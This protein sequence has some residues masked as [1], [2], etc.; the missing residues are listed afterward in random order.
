MRISN[1]GKN[2]IKYFEGLY[3]HAYRCPAGVLTI[4]W[5]CTEGVTEGM[6]ITT[7]RA[8][9]LLTAELAK[10]EAAVARLVRVPLTQH[11]FDALVS[12]AFNVGSGAL[13]RSTLLRKLNA[14]DYAAVPGELARWTRGGGRVLPGLVKRRRAEA[15]LWSSPDAEIHPIT[16]PMAQ[17]V[18]APKQEVC[19]PQAII[20]LMLGLVGSAIGS[21]TGAGLTVAPTTTATNFVSAI[22]GAIMAAIGGQA[23]GGDAIHTVG[24]I[25]GVVVAVSA[26]LN[27]LHI[28]NASNANTLEAI[29]HMLEQAGG[30][31]PQEPTDTAAAA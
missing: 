19:M 6:T 28:T 15:A 18:D 5:G 9:Q 2:A 1:A 14:G 7:E 22:V 25:G 10:F 21:R 29:G 23:F 8:E 31:A 11:Q 13:E 20:N 24:A 16:E 4:G 12:F 17:R 30:Q 27:Q 26:L 3:L